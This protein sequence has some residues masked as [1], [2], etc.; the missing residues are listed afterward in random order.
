M[1]TTG[2]LKKGLT[3]E[4]EGQP[5]QILDWQHIKMGRGGA[6]VRLKTRNLRTGAITDRSYD[7]GERFKRLYLDRSN[8]IY[9]YNDGQFYHFMDNSTYEDIALTE[10]QLG[11]AKNY[12]I[13]NME[14]DIVRY[15]D[16]PISVELPEKVV[17]KVTYT[18]PGFKGDTATGGSKPATT[19]TGFV[20]QVPLFVNIGDSIRVNTSTG[21]YVERV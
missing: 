2:D 13:D 5:C 4:V 17:L 16:E 9:Q 18:E 1:I 8:V 20:V 10:E 3:I 14:L 6:I 15:N 21:Q 12:L 19:E 7:A 11:D